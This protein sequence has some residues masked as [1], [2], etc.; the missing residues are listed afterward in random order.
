MGK[1]DCCVTGLQVKSYDFKIFGSN[2][3]TNVIKK[4]CKSASSF[5]AAAWWTSG[6]PQALQT[7]CLAG[8]VCF[9][10]GGR[11]EV[12]LQLQHMF[13]FS[14]L[15]RLGSLFYFKTEFL[16]EQLIAGCSNLWRQECMNLLPRFLLKGWG[17]KIPLCFA[18]W[19]LLVAGINDAIY[20][21][22]MPLYVVWSW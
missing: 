21:V 19:D 11:Y 15:V 12:T 4:A 9:W 2:K 1:Y 13:C 7:S 10:D 20:L 17:K 14:Y 22:A 5:E 8:G 3:S 16:N 18:C 6:L